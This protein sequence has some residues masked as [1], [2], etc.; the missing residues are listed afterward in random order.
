MS[1]LENEYDVYVA[2]PKGIA[3][4]MAAAATAFVAGIRAGI[5]GG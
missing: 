2:E 5:K 4:L 1:I 3:E